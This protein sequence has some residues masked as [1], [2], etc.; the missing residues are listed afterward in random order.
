[1]TIKK[2]DR[3][4]KYTKMILRDSFIKLLTDK[5][6]SKISI[7]EI[8]ELADINRSTFYSHYK[9]QYD[10]LFQIEQE[11]IE[12][13]NNYLKNYYFND[14]KNESL[15]LLRS[16]FEYIKDNSELCRILLSDNGNTNFQKEIMNI[17]QQQCL[18]SWASS[19]SVKKEDAEYILVFS[20]IGSVGIIQKWLR[21]DMKKPTIEIAEL[22]L[23][24]ANQG[25]AS[26]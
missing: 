14:S 10:L 8:C 3:R 21:E 2:I 15:Y 4:V 20:A 13:I 24:I 18:A 12:E 1:M 5:P 6:I 11:V 9:D 7:K 19:K 17:V 25:L 22:V 23:K 16:I 26:F